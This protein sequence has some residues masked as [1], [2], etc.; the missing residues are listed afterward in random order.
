MMIMYNYVQLCI[1]MHNYAW[2]CIIMHNHEFVIS[3]C[4]RFM[5]RM[6]PKLVPDRSGMVPEWSRTLLGHFWVKPFKK[7]KK[8]NVKHVKQTWN[9]QTSENRFFLGK[10]EMKKTR[11]EIPLTMTC[12][13]APHLLIWPRPW[14][15][16]K[17]EQ[18]GPLGPG[19][20]EWAQ[21]ARAQGPNEWP[22]QGPNEWPQRGPNE[23]AQQGSNFIWGHLLTI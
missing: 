1:I 16:R 12:R 13:T 4:R 14:Q 2:L 21:W 15:K 20:N 23:W 17:M 10:I 7:M 5:V 11:I 19:P 6:G 8:L 3:V 9:V 18:M 22:Q